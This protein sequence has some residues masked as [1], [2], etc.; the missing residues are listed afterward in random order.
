MTSEPTED[1]PGK[2]AALKK[3][4][5]FVLLGVLVV[6]VILR[7]P[8]EFETGLRKSLAAEVPDQGFMDSAMERSARRFERIVRGLW[9]T[10]KIAHR[11]EAMKLVGLKMTQ[12]Q[13]TTLGRYRS[14]V[15]NGLGDRDSSVREAAMNLLVRVER[16]LATPH[17]LAQLDDSDHHLRVIAMWHL[18]HLGVTNALPLIAGQL[19]EADPE[20][21]Y[22]SAHWMQRVTGVDHGMGGKLVSRRLLLSPTRPAHTLTNYQVARKSALVWW[23]NHRAGY[24]PVERLPLP[25]S[26]PERNEGLQLA[27]FALRRGD[28]TKFDC[29]ALEGRPVLL[30]FFTTWGMHAPATVKRVFQLAGDRLPVLGISLDAILDNHNLARLSMELGEPGH[31]WHEAVDHELPYDLRDVMAAVEPRIRQHGFQFPIVYDLDGRLTR[32]MQGGEIPA[33]VLLDR[34][35]RLV[36]R[37]AGPRRAETLLT[38]AVRAGLLASLEPRLASLPQLPEPQLV[39]Q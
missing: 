3:R 17:L 16:S 30:Y 1:R 38:T 23:E 20:L 8:V 9:R 26:D 5:Q 39:N 34:K 29:A 11:Q 4:R 18:R 25:L 36:R 10:G 15:E 28:L 19:R 37:F 21:V 7:E 27:E 32:L 22:E 13:A 2:P 14:F 33:Y 31:F 24:R 6:L 12:E 35:H